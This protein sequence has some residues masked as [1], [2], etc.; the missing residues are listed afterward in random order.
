MYKT[1]N[2]F[3]Y[4]EDFDWSE[5][6][7]EDIETIERE[8]VDENVYRFLND[9]KKNDIVLDIGASVGAY[10]ISILDHNPKKVFCVE[11]SK[12]LLKTL[13]KN[14]S[15]KLFENLETTI[16]YINRAI[17]D[18]DNDNVNVFG[19][20]KSFIP[21]TFGDLI[22]KYNI[23][24][25]DFMKVDCEGGEY[26]IF[27]TTN[28]DFLIN[29]VKFIAVEIHLKQE[30]FRD[31]FKFFRDNVLTKF[32]KYKVMSC[33]RQEILYGQSIEITEKIFDN[34]FIDEYDCEFM[35]YIDNRDSNKVK[36]NIFLDCGSHL[37]QGFEQFIKI[38]SIDENWECHSFESNPITYK[39][40]LP[41][42]QNLLDSGLNLK[43][44]N[45]AVLDEE[46]YVNVNCSVA[47]DYDESEIGTYTGQGSNV[48][49][50]PPSGWNFTYEEHERKVKSINFSNFIKENFSKDDYIVVKM[51][52]E[53]SEFSVLDGLI[54]DNMVEYID[55]IYVE[56]HERFF[57]NTS[58]YLE[59]KEYY[60]KLFH[61][62]GI[63]FFE[64]Y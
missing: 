8:I 57:E 53:G 26:C 21:I 23:T 48:L 16:T 49:K 41:K 35:I 61:D 63:K 40:S 54:R 37:F 36:K 5:M 12:T 33:T 56:F 59:K 17:V 29:N 38:L 45:Y 55:E 47:Y 19:T 58:L 22:K 7:Y 62:K 52:I 3:Y 39:M 20:D 2:K 60:K 15:E 1:Y 9:V 31:K 30:G 14:C 44:Y 51:D 18:K 13:A 25:I 4:P 50:K 10:T 46:T 64:W 32:K 27:N 34:K 6:T 24:N 42:Y 28:I 43:H 11:P